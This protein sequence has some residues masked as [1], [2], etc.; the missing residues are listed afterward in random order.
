[1]AICLLNGLAIC[2]SGNF[3]SEDCPLQYIPVVPQLCVED[4]RGGTRKRNEPA[5]DTIVQ[6][7]PKL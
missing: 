1:M 6:Q 3:D 7:I 5:A 4:A 2:L